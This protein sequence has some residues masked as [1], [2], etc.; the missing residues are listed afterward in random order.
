MGYNGIGTQELLF[1]HLK[2]HENL[3]ANRRIS[4]KKYRIMRGGI[5]SLR[6]F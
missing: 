3:N 6:L 2:L 4:N 5:A 1:T